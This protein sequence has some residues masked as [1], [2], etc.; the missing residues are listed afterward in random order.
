MKKETFEEYIE[1]YIDFYKNYHSNDTQLQKLTI[2]TL[3][4]I[5]NRYKKEKKENDYV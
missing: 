3:H 4:C 1:H 2:T 5:L